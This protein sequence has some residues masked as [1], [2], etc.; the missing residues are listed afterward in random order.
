MEEV[1]KSHP[2]QSLTRIRHPMLRRIGVC[3]T[4]KRLSY[5]PRHK[6]QVQ[7]T[8]AHRNAGEPSTQISEPSW[9]DWP[10]IADAPEITEAESF[11]ST[12]VLHRV[13]ILCRPPANAETN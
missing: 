8:P 4:S 5:R 11:P 12:I 3:S 2:R 1:K 7:E 10:I 6:A 9:W 13:R